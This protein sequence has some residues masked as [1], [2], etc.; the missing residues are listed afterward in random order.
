MADGVE[1]VIETPLDA[2]ETLPELGARWPARF[3]QGV[4]KRQDGVV[5]LLDAE[6][7]FAPETAEGL[8]N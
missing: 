1:E 3:V 6:T 5:V 4:A 7:L 2:L 8:N